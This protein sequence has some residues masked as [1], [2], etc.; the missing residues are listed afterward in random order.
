[1]IK[2]GLLICN[3]FI[4]FKKDRFDA[5]YDLLI[6]EFKKEN[7]ELIKKYNYEVLNII[8]EDIKNEYDF[9]IFW[10]KDIHLAKHLE[11]LGL[12]VFN[13]SKAIEI[14]DNKSKTYLELEKY[15][16]QMPKTIIA[17]FK[18]NIC[19]YDYSFIDKV[20]DKLGLPLIIKEN[21]GSFGQQVYM[22][23]TKD[24]I[25]NKINEINTSEFLFQE[26]IASSFGKDC[27]IEVVG[28]EVLGS[29][30]RT[31]SND[32]RS[33]VLQGGNMEVFNAPK[34]Y[35]D[36]ALKVSNILGLDFCGVDLLFGENNKPIL[37]E[38]NSN[39]HFKTFFLKTGKNLA[40]YL[41]NYIKN[42]LQ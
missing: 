15:N 23:S 6:N 24:E 25:I 36:L 34:E 5:L 29:V 41:V 10:D 14:C 33:N 17:P 39:V 26:Y 4:D 12:K 1:M 3:G 19:K 37:C 38:V 9:V 40:S 32:F 21:Y 35:Y 42:K 11:N 20:I 18:Y 13:S 30:I 28:N 2:K 31:N 27:R 22:L 8:N 7:I 16:I